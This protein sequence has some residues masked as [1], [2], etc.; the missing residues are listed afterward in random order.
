MKLK[1]N[2]LEPMCRSFQSATISSVISMQRSCCGSLCRFGS[3]SAC[4]LQNCS[5]QLEL[6]RFLV[7]LCT[8]FKCYRFFSGLMLFVELER[9]PISSQN[10]EQTS[11]R[12]DPNQLIHKNLPMVR[13]RTYS[14]QHVQICP[15]DIY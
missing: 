12:N 15:S 4:H 13:S 5:G 2:S 8:Q 7:V 14:F 3:I 11:P 10:K 1:N 9:T 6:T